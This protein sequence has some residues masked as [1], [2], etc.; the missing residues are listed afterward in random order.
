MEAA[1]VGPPSCRSLSPGLSAAPDQL[2]VLTDILIG[3]G[4]SLSH[5]A[6]RTAT[7][8]GRRLLAGLI[9]SR[10][11]VRTLFAIRQFGKMRVSA[12]RRF[13]DLVIPRDKRVS[14]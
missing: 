5:G 9:E 8:V 11:I 12:I 3:T 2:L 14:G 10:R 4:C 6:G 1:S 13:G 7:T